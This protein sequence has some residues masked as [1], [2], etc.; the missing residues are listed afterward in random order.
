[1]SLLA[2][3]KNQEIDVKEFLEGQDEEVVQDRMFGRI[4]E[5]L[6][7]NPGSY[8]WDSIAPVS[9][10][11]AIAFWILRN[12]LDLAFPQTAHGEYLSLLSESHG[13]PRRE[14]QRASSILTLTGEKGVSISSGTLFCT[15]VAQGSAEDPK[16]YKTTSD[17]T[18]PEYGYVEV[19]I[20]AELNG[21]AGNVNAGEINV[22]I[23]KL[24]G[25][26]S[27]KNVSPVESGYDAEDDKT[28]LARTLERVR[29]PPVAGSRQDYVR[30]AKEVTGVGDAVIQPL[31]DGPGTVKV[32]ITDVDGQIA[33]EELLQA[34][35]DYI[36]PVDG[37]GDGKAP[38]GATVTICTVDTI[39]ID[40]TIPDLVC[41]N[42]YD[43]EN[44]LPELE[45][46]I[47]KYLV[48]VI[49]GEIVRMKGIE[50]AI[51]ATAGV[52]DYDC[53]LLNGKKENIP[54]AEEQK[55][56]LGEVMLS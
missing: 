50:A 30:W 32:I 13:V 26:T 14:A 52:L 41:V 24:P 9:L 25:I 4:D 36:S 33:N 5:D 47:K 12:S 55:A 48:S 35:K 38:I 51:T 2:Q 8:I 39:N 40:V 21:A 17:V 28:L 11:L 42:G 23:Q 44:I 1:M 31:W 43:F 49:P 53:V 15:T 3:I 18:I 45:V 22:N 27:V 10:E 46:S 19:P 6:D 37:M 20:E 16:Y 29:N 34:V 54:I 56:V 7:K